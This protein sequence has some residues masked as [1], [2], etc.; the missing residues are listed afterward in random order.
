MSSTELENKVNGLSVRATGVQSVGL[1]TREDYVGIEVVCGY[2]KWIII[3]N[4][5]DFERLHSLLLDLRIEEASQLT[6]G[7]PLRR[8]SACFPNGFIVIQQR[9][10]SSL[11][12]YFRLLVNS[13]DLLA[14]NA[15]RDF[16]ELKPFAFVRND[17]VNGYNQCFIRR[18]GTSFGH[19][20]LES[21]R[22]C[23]TLRRMLWLSE[24][25]Q[26]PC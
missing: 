14:L 8:P 26:L 11:D 22:E 25:H 21:Q 17:D 12:R 9:D 18:D 24:I 5:R 16:L 4:G 10:F 19:T 15:V 13:R 3:R 7:Y 1:D 23:F 20:I 6:A 2:S